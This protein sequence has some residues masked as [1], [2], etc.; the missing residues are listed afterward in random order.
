MKIATRIALCA[1][2][3]AV[4]A[5]TVLAQDAVKVAPQ[6]YKLIAEND[7]V[8]VIEVSLAPGTTTVTHSHPAAL[9]VILEGGSVKWTAP[10]GK[11][12]QSPPGLKRGSVI[13]VPAETHTSENIGKATTRSIIVEFKKPAPAEGKG[14]SP[15][16]PSPYK[17]VAD[18]AH[19]R[20]F[21]LVAPAGSSVAQHTHAAQVLVSLA[22][23]TAETTDSAGKKDT[24]TFKKDTAQ[25]GTPV[26]HSA[27]NTGKSAIHL[28][29]IELK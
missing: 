15:S 27:V 1:S 22:D 7:S 5:A 8:R 4:A 25:I 6:Q 19:A 11:S 9:A 21:E 16:M 26:T 18:H 24:M 12:T 17:Q 13:Y 23:G 2:V 28:I 29:S 14:R 3:L 10:G 20:V